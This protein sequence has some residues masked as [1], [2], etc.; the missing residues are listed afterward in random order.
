MERQGVVLELQNQFAVLLTKDGQFIRVPRVES[1]A[2]GLEYQFDSALPAQPVRR[3]RNY[4]KARKQLWQVISAGVAACV[5]VAAGIVGEMHLHPAG[6]EAYAFVSLDINPSISL[7]VSK[8]YKVI[9]ATGINADGAMLLKHVS[10]RGETLRA[11]VA[12]IV[13]QAT[14]SNMLPSD[15]TILVATAPLQSSANINQLQAAA[16]ADVTAAVQ[17]NAAARAKHPNVYAVSLS[18]TVWKAASE[19]RVSPGKLAAFLVARHEGLNVSLSQLNGPALARIF[20][21][22]KPQSPLLQALQSNNVQQV[23]TEIQQMVNGGVLSSIV[24]K[25][26]QSESNQ[27]GENG[28]PTANSSSDGRDPTPPGGTSS[29][30]THSHDKDKSGDGS[31]VTVQIGNSTFSLP[32]GNLDQSVVSGN[33]SDGAFG[34]NKQ[35]GNDKHGQTDHGT[36]HDNTRDSKGTKGEGSTK[37]DP[38]NTNEN[39][40]KATTNSDWM[41]NWV[42][43]LTGS[44]ENGD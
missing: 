10:V 21:G 33:G 27:T 5:A 14:V 11:A 34:G 22:T 38:Q 42:N 9:D 41:N 36:G 15:D 37:G 13:Q 31:G 25:P 44:Y 1:M 26:G 2:V 29:K 4:N 28:T 19:A 24:P 30:E 17:S 3:N 12:D 16:Q 32:L 20:G 43:E 8:D 35:S 6:V 40:G 7:Q 39:G 18:T 23:E